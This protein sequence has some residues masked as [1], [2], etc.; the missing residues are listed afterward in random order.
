MS[1]LCIEQLCAHEKDEN[2][3]KLALGIGAKLLVGSAAN[4]IDLTADQRLSR[5]Q[6]FHVPV[7]LI[8]R[9]VL[10]NIIWHLQELFLFH[11]HYLLLQVMGPT[12][13]AMKPVSS[14]E[15]L[16]SMIPGEAALDACPTTPSI[17]RVNRATYA[18]AI[19]SSSSD[20]REWLSKIRWRRETIN[21][22][23]LFVPSLN[24]LT[25]ALSINQRL[26]LL[27]KTIK[28]EVIQ[29]PVS[30]MIGNGP[31]SASVSISLTH[32]VAVAR[33]MSSRNGSRGDSSSR[34]RWRICIRS[35][36]DHMMTCSLSCSKFGGGAVCQLV[37]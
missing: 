11:Q 26:T 20:T 5:D 19:S 15:P 2:P 13:S 29:L 32:L 30:C 1:S 33:H 4:I 24:I 25:S 22:F 17:R 7:L 34:W 3:G 8:F 10:N 9:L 16:L 6:E 23:W 36:I 31:W 18:V 28:A 27:K 37:I 12:N 35:R 21:V 14:L